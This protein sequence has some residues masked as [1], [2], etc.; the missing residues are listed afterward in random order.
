MEALNA[1][2]LRR[3]RPGA[4]GAPTDPD[5]QVSRIRLFGTHGFATRGTRDSASA[6]GNAGGTVCSVGGLVQA[7]RTADSDVPAS[8]MNQIVTEAGTIVLCC[9]GV[10]D[11]AV[12]CEWF[13]KQ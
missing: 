7:L 6:A 8:V 2:A 1:K 11:A 4:P 13:P 3:R 12:G 10:W 9:P 5:V